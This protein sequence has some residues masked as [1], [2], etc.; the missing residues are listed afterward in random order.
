MSR[1]TMSRTTSVTIGA[2][3]DEFVGQLIESG[4]YGSTSEVVRSALR[5]LEKQ[6]KQLTALKMAIEAGERSGECSRSLHDIAS[7]V[8][9]RHNV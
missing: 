5:L 3:L 1:T 8:K 6:E 2:P 4:R 7:K 9:S